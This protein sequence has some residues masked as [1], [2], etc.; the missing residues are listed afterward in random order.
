MA[1]KSKCATI[2]D[3][4]ARKACMAKNLRTKNLAT[5]GFGPKR[6]RKRPPVEPY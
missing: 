4:K 3:P 6:P 5:R 2:R 1:N